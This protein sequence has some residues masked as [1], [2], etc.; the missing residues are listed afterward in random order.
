LVEPINPAGDQQT[1]AVA[2]DAAQIGA[3]AARDQLFPLPGPR[4]LGGGD[5]EIDVVVVGQDP[6]PPVGG[7]G[8]I[9]DVRPARLDQGQRRGGIIGRDEADLVRAVVARGDED[10]LVVGRAHGRDG[11]GDVLFL[12]V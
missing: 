12:F 10:Q 3:I 4:Q 8:F 1:V 7:I 5:A 6:Q 11:E 9:L 2:G